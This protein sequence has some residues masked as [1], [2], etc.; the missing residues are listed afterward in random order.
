MTN[1][2]IHLNNLIFTYKNSDTSYQFENISFKTGQQYL[3]SGMSG[4]GKSTLM[5]LLAGLICPDQGDIIIAGQKLFSMNSYRRDHFRSTHIGLIFQD[6]KLI[7]YLNVAEN[8]L[9]PYQ[10]NGISV[11]LDWFK[12]IMKQLQINELQYRSVQQLSLGQRQRVAIARAMVCRPMILL[13]DEPTASLDK[14]L[15]QDFLELIADFSKDTIQII[16]SHDSQLVQ[17]FDNTIMFQDLLK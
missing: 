11:D 16:V 13:A 15:T 12:K 14:H 1:N 8:I 4:C 3:I 10:L 2:S 7:N 6:H 17:Y 9:I 5:A